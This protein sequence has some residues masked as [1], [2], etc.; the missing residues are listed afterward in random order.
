M[1]EQSKLHFISAGNT[2]DVLRL[3]R[4]F[5][6]LSDHYFDVLFS[7]HI[8]DDIVFSSEIVQKHLIDAINDT[9]VFRMYCGKPINT[10]TD[11]KFSG[12]GVDITFRLTDGILHMI[13][14]RSG[15]ATYER[16]YV[17]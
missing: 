16:K 10:Q 1:I 3:I 4:Y 5:D 8:P 6:A 17:G 2:N 11:E 7:D 13:R 14:I 15:E 12:N 9:P